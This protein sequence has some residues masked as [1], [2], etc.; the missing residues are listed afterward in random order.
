MENLKRYDYLL[1]DLG[2]ESNNYEKVLQKTSELIN[3]QHEENFDL[4]EDI[5]DAHS[6]DEGLLEVNDDSFSESGSTPIKTQ[7]YEDSGE[8]DSDTEE[9]YLNET[10]NESPI[11]AAGY[12]PDE[13]DPIIDSIFSN[14]DTPEYL[15]KRN[16]NGFAPKY[17]DSGENFDMEEEEETPI[18]IDELSEMYGAPK[19]LEQLNNDLFSIDSQKD[20]FPD[21]KSL[22]SEAKEVMGAKE[23]EAESPFGENLEEEIDL[24]GGTKNLEETP[25]LEENIMP[26]EVPVEEI[27]QLEE[28]IGLSGESPIPSL[29]ENVSDLE[30]PNLENMEIEETGL[31]LTQANLQEEKLE[32]IPEISDIGLSQGEVEPTK[33]TAP[34]LEEGK[35]GGELSHLE[36][37]MK[38]EK[39]EEIS[40]DLTGEHAEEGLEGNEETLL[41]MPSDLNLEEAEI[42]EE[43]K[44]PVENREEKISSFEEKPVNL[45]DEI[46]QKDEMNL[47]ELHEE[48]PI[49]EEKFN[50]DNW[51][52][53]LR[54]VDHEEGFVRKIDEDQF[55][56]RK[57][58][59]E[60]NVEKEDRTRKEAEN[61]I[62]SEES[63]SDNEIA[64]IQANLNKMPAGLGIHIRNILL[65]DKANNRLKEEISIELSRSNPNI[66]HLKSLSRYEAKEE[67]EHKSQFVP[68]FK[69]VAVI[70][71]LAVVFSGIY[72]LLLKPYFDKRNLLNSGLIDI[73]NGNYLAANSKFEKASPGIE[74]YNR[75]ALKFLEKN[76]TVEAEKKLTG[77]HDGANI[78]V[79]GAV[80]LD[81]NDE[82]TRFNIAR[83]YLEQKRYEK[84]LEN[85]I[86][87]AKQYDDSL[88][89]L[90]N[91]DPNNFKV[92]DK[93]GD[94]Y[95]QWADDTKTIPE[96]KEKL[97]N[98][99]NLYLKYWENH[100]E[101]VPAI[102]KML[103]LSAK[104]DD[105]VDKKIDH[106]IM[107]KGLLP[108]LDHR[109]LAELG[110]YYTDRERFKI[111]YDIIQILND[112]KTEEPYAYYMIGKYFLRAQNI[113]NAERSLAKGDHFNGVYNSKG[114]RIKNIDNRLESKIAGLLGEVYVRL[115]EDY[116]GPTK[117]NQEKQKQ[118]IDLANYHFRIAEE[119]DPENPLIPYYQG[120]MHYRF[121]S[122]YNKSAEL[123]LQA[124]ALF[125]EKKDR[126]P[127]ELY[128]NLSNSLYRIGDYENSLEYLTTLQQQ[129]PTIRIRPAVN[130]MMGMIYYK[131]NESRE[132]F[133]DESRE[134][135]SNVI[136]YYNDEIQGYLRSPN[137]LSVRQNKVFYFTAIT[138]NNIGCI[139]N[140]LG[141]QKQDPAYFDLARAEFYKAIE[142]GNR[143]NNRNVL[144]LSRINLKDS[145]FL[146]N[147]R[148]M[149]NFRIG[150]RPTLLYDDFTPKY[151]EE[152]E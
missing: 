44:V 33:E 11:D 130:Y 5:D 41:E 104:L 84:V 116:L 126:A 97:Q 89:Y 12:V 55:N 73:E 79:P 39:G 98:A 134:K 108:K 31:D 57:S 141:I 133:L 65:D 49:E 107:P 143:Y 120:N 59:F 146:D 71:V 106:Y 28:E 19:E 13:T 15:E 47:E 87:A 112:Q 144:A 32:E 24:T 135:L 69:T 123:Y 26:E 76:N 152:F 78:L 1:E 105:E 85:D 119:N 54:D 45:Q 131:L 3:S 62:A 6:L 20:N 30:I 43:K 14:L 66:H 4:P 90:Y 117:L 122:D 142:N 139:Y 25:T 136:E 128:Y 75:Y 56:R 37:F 2:E 121:F 91:K 114:L 118:F 83:V 124:H 110:E 34:S 100:L 96:K 46:I 103:Y 7:D 8:S 86:E 132:R 68:F 60:Y 70:A 145:I 147:A 17:I 63:F 67:K 115:A 53:D 36:D 129:N 99:Y 22:L 113:D 35:E 102:S 10:S 82:E 138:H 88:Y 93:I 150:R 61:K 81:P 127:V 74:W 95:A 42:H 72:F 125:Q 40:F 80:D 16:S 48:L 77:T 148:Y 151:I 64:R 50:F 101:E 94:V 51:E 18:E 23:E 58:E 29:E 9:S 21:I 111:V 38:G 149:D 27:P 109:T 52:K 140:A 92:V 137:P